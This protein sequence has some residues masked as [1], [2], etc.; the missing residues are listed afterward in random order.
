MRGNAFEGTRASPIVDGMTIDDG[1]IYLLR[2]HWPSI[3]SQLLQRNLP[4]TA[5]QAG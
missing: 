1:K 5:G 2:E 3:Q 4:A